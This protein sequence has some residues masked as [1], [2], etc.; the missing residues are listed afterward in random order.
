MGA[1]QDCPGSRPGG[2]GGE[3]CVELLI[4]L[5][6]AG[7]VD[8]SRLDE[9]AR[10]LLKVK[11]QLGLF[12]NPYVDEEAAAAIVGRQDFR[13]EGYAAQARSVTVLSTGDGHLPAGANRGHAIAPLALPLAR[14]LRIYAE[15]VSA[16]AVARLGTLVQRPEHADVAIVRLL[17]P[18]EPRS[19]LFLEDWF[20]QGSLEFPP[21]L[22]ERLARVAAHCPLVVDVLLDRPAVLTPL[23]PL[24]SVL[25]VSY[26]TCDD[27]LI[28][29][30][31]G[32]CTRKADSL[33]TY[34]GR[35]SRC[36][37][38]PRT[39][40]A[41]TSRCFDWDIAHSPKTWPRASA[42][43]GLND[44]SRR[45]RVSPAETGPRPMPLGAARPG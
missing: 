2:A 31:S 14:G 28:D 39:S 36:D 15:R 1:E 9:S 37:T 3:E 34:R 43:S 26:G 13:E 5:V 18:L 12:D 30:L 10:R 8:E 20:H 44:L 40:L 19:D 23:L 4:D 27:A 42:G 35:W 7:R 29:V 21:G 41:M 17:A 33:S 22:V 16:A 24:V 25:V 38:I 32:A 45:S 6:K 11:F